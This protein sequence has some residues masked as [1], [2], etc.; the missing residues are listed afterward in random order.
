[1][2]FIS[3][4]APAPKAPPRLF[5]PQAPREAL[6]R[7]GATEASLERN[8]NANPQGESGGIAPQRGHRA[9]LAAAACS[10]LATPCR[11]QRFDG[12]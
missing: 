8:W 6:V 1:M 10:M 11:A 5:F 4:G 12:W 7:V 2:A 9:S 3:V